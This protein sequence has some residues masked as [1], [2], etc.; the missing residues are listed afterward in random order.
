MGKEVEENCYLVRESRR[1]CWA[2]GIGHRR[3]PQ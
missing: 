2:Y 1:T 3:A